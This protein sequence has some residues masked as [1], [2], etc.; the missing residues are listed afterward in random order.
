MKK[1]VWIRWGIVLVAMILLATLPFALDPDKK[2][3]FDPEADPEMTTWPELEGEPPELWVTYCWPERWIAL[4]DE[5][6]DNRS[7]VKQVAFY[8]SAVDVRGGVNIF[9]FRRR[10]GGLEEARESLEKR[11]MGTVIRSEPVEDRVI[12]G[13]EMAG[14]IDWT[15]IS[16]TTLGSSAQAEGDTA[17]L[18]YRG[19]RDGYE[20]QIEITDMNEGH[21]LLKSVTLER[22]LENIEFLKQ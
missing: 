20:Y 6:M 13:I 10:D 4:P 21:P 15:P 19:R 2:I 14:V 22:I 17:V 12:G 7:L 5:Y 16:F 8:P 18:Q 9:I 3:P 11:P 1:S